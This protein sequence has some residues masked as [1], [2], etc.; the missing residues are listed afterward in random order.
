MVIIITVDSCQSNL[1]EGRIAVAHGRF[2]RIRQVAPMCTSS[3]TWFPGPTRLSIPNCISIDSAVFAQLT[4]ESLYFIMGRRFLPLKLPGH[5]H[6][7][8]DPI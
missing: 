7:D 6:G 3:N 5:S 1:T 2:N 8:L 4:T